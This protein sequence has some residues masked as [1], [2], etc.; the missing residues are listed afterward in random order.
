MD[1]EQLL[2]DAIAHQWDA[3]LVECYGRLSADPAKQL[4]TVEAWLRDH[5]TDP[6]ALLAAGRLAFASQAWDKAREYLE[7]SLR[8]GPTT[9][10]YVELARVCLLLGDPERAGKY[11][12]R[13]A[14]L[15]ATGDRAPAATQEPGGQLA[16]GA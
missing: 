9:D 13:I 6:V 7:A 4:D 2:I 16:R 14:D 10:V 11:L 1:A 5:S 3:R 15:S 8:A 12:G